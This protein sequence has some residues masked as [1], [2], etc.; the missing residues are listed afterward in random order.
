[1]TLRA[2]LAAKTCSCLVN[3]LMPFRLGVAGLL[4]TMILILQRE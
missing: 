1:M 3:G 2:G 4:M